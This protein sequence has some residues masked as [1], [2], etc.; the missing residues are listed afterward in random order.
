MGDAAPG[1]TSPTGVPSSGDSIAAIEAEYKRKQNHSGDELKSIF[2]RYVALGGVDRA[3]EIAL[4]IVRDADPNFKAARALLGH[5]EFAHDVPDVIS[6][7]KYPYIRAVEEAS[8][9]RW[10]DDKEAYDLAEEAWKKTVAHAHRIETD[11][12]F[13]ALDGARREIDRDPRFKNYNY[14]AIFASP[15]LICYSSDERLTEE[16]F[17]KLN[18]KDRASQARR[19]REVARELPAHPGGEGEDLPAALQGVPEALRGGRAS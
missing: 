10:F 1:A 16:D 9:Q 15:Y 4:E 7:R 14:E 2:N 19:A 3:K 18:K 12:A 5:Y 11:S 6:N 8:M 13:R 17:L